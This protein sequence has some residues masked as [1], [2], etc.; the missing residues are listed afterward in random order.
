M[1]DRPD[2]TASSA[3]GSPDP[4]PPAT[5]ERVSIITGHRLCATCR[6][7][8]TGQPV[9]R[10]PHYGLLV[11]RCPE[12]GTVAG[13]QEYPLLG[14]WV[15]R[16]GLVVAITWYAVMIVLALGLA[17]A[18]SGMTVAIAG[19]AVDSYARTL[20]SEHDAFRLARNPDADP[21]KLWQLETFEE[22]WA[23]ADPARIFADAG[24]WRGVIE[25]DEMAALIIPIGLAG[26]IGVFFAIALLHRGRRTLLV[27]A[28][29]VALLIGAG[30]AL[31][32]SQLRG[33]DSGPWTVASRDV[34]LP[35]VACAFGLVW[36]SFTAALLLG[37]P[38][39]RAAVRGLLPPRLRRPLAVLWEADGRTPPLA[40]D[41]PD[42]LRP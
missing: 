13:A 27:V 17:A 19:E 7:N 6:Y 4:S 35:A 31:A 38:I 39:A 8:L 30:L 24:G 5:E 21:T 32:W 28:T 41:R 10:E 18:T 25:W 12:C 16:W 29:V 20:R 15:A 40:S 23:E 36:L 3:P 42:G 1:T 33:D 22:F 2:L 9:L 37:R 26:V 14:R 34:T 11:V